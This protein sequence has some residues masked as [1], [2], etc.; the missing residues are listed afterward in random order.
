MFKIAAALF[1][2][3]AIATAAPAAAQAQQEEITV[4]VRLNGLDLNHLADQQRLEERVNYAIRRACRVDARDVAS[5]R[6][7][8]S[9][10]ANL[11]D[12]LVPR[13]ELA[14]ADARR[15]YLAAIEAN[16]GA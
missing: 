5:R 8:R 6:V 9:C 13:V 7:Q 15:E 16:P 10:E 11:S 1:A 12:Q 3:S 4:K 2:I 14:I